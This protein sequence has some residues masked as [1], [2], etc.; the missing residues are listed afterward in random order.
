VTVASAQARMTVGV[1]VERRK[2]RSPWIDFTW[3][4]VAVLAGLPEAAPWTM[5]S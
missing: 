3:K 4:P 2:A 1:V 5:L